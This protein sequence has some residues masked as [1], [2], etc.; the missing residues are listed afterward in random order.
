MGKP[1]MIILIRHAQSE[2]NKNRAIHQTVPDHRVKLTPQGWKE[3][4]DAGIRLRSLLNADDTLKFF[5]SPYRRTRETTE[6]ILSTLTSDDPT[7]SPFPRRKI[8]VYEE[9]RLREQD[10]GNFQPSSD[11]MERMWQ[12]RADYG[13]FFYRIP[14]GESAADAYD[15]ISG[16]NESLWRQFGEDDSAS[17]FVL[18]THGLMTRVFLMKW[19]HFSVEYFEDLRNV[20][21]CEFVIMNLNPDNG[22]YIL[23]TKLRTWSELKLDRVLAE[24]DEGA[25][26]T[27]IRN[28]ADVSIPVRKKWLGCRSS[29]NLNDALLN[30]REHHQPQASVQV[31]ASEQPDD[32][33]VATGAPT[34]TTS[35]DDGDSQQQRQQLDGPS[36]PTSPS[37][38]EDRAYSLEGRDFGGSMSGVGSRAGSCSSSNNEEED[39][40][41]NDDEKH[42]SSVVCP[43]AASKIN[44][45]LMN[46]M[47]H[48]D[49]PGDDAGTTMLRAQAD[50]LGDHHLE[51]GSAD[52]N[53]VAG[54]G[55]RNE[56]EK[57]GTVARNH[58]MEELEAWDRS[59]QGSVY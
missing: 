31:P 57:T 56:E 2:G 44:E 29:S 37:R 30:A 21:H 15:R 17:V 46:D 54:E 11:E 40:D 49:H 33:R 26:P 6:G 14:N 42:P 43:A 12:E 18:V 25:S 9:P 27:K 35:D 58:P 1:R 50:R 23:E 59:V 3:A 22:K 52:G 36:S 16:F 47:N 4:A 45:A 28:E 7:P 24:N 55:E 34:T 39:D 8:K 53:A 19:Y 48:A 13:H 32:M 10:F 38:Q 5:T 51:S 20:N 41:D